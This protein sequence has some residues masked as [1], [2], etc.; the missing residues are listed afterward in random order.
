MVEE[1]LSIYKKMKYIRD[2]NQYKIIEYPDIS[3]IRMIKID[4]DTFSMG[5]DD[6]IKLDEKPEH[7]VKINSFFMSEFLVSQELY[8]AVMKTNPSK[9]KN[10]KS[11]V[12]SVSWFQA[13]DF[14][15]ELTRILDLEQA[16]IDI[17]ENVFLNVRKSG[18]R[19]C[20]EAEWEFVAK[21]GIDLAYFSSKQDDF[22]QLKEIIWYEE[23]G[24]NENSLIGQQKENKL[25]LQDF[26][27]DFFEWCWDEY[28]NDFYKLC[29]ESREITHFIN[30]S[31]N[32][33]ARVIR[34]GYWRHDKKISRISTRNYC[35]PNYRM[36]NIGFRLCMTN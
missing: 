8:R 25:G 10:K 13:I 36:G 19:L 31:K 27:N 29:K 11:P 9:I 12:D 1:F 3:T 20:T 2:E 18:I 24:V 35:N 28:S 16:I 22:S 17:E 6:S 30:N 34:G 14:C 15:R 5:D 4:G 33:K 7:K 32:K 21:K 26:G 23:N